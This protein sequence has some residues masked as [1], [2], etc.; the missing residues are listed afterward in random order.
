MLCVATCNI[1]DHG[2]TIQAEAE[3]CHCTV[4]ALQHAQT[5]AGA[6]VPYPNA[7]VHRGG[8]ELQPVNVW[9]ELDQSGVTEKHFKYKVFFS[10]H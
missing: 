1:P 2:V 5:L 7:A 9:V 3:R 8:E 6:Q 4:V 10:D